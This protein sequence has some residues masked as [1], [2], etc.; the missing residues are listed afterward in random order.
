MTYR[1][2]SIPPSGP[3]ARLKLRHRAILAAAWAYT[4]TLRAAG[5]QG[6]A[7]AC[8]RMV[9]VAEDA[10][11]T[12]D[13]MTSAEALRAVL[14]LRGDL[15]SLL[16]LDGMAKLGS[17]RFLEAQPAFEDSS[18]ADAI[19]EASDTVVAAVVENWINDPDRGE[20]LMFDDGDALSLFDDTDFDPDPVPGVRR[21]FLVLVG[22]S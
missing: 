6:Y 4:G 1:R 13:R 8:A 12:A 17:G 9:A 22:E 2:A 21:P 14:R 7:R 20:P 15:E 11:C 18:L 5:D 16:V 3:R 10:L 19:L